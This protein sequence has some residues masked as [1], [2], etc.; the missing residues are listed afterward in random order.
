MA[1]KIQTEKP[2]IPVEI[3]NLRFSFD[4][5]DES[6]KK[7]RKEAL[8]VQK[9]FHSITVSEDDDEA[10]EQAKSVL[11]RGF[12]LILGEGAFEKI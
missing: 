7:F 8:E 6:I 11:K 3:G 4:V 12:E 2:E 1:I 9:E 5:S 10:L